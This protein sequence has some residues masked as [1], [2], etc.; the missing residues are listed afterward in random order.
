MPI[1]KEYCARYGITLYEITENKNEYPTAHWCKLDV[2]RQFLDSGHEYGLYLDIDIIIRKEAPNIFNEY[3]GGLSMTT[4]LDH[5]IGLWTDL[6]DYGKYFDFHE[7]YNTGVI[8][9][10]KVTVA[11]ILNHIESINISSLNHPDLL[12]QFYFNKWFEWN[13]YYKFNWLYYF[14]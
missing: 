14:R 11:K 13:L 6:W 10:D 8:L 1:I 9:F 12:D 2:F 3:N 4:D 7:Y 5:N